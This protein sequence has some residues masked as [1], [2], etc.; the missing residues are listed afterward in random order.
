MNMLLCTFHQ[1]YGL[2]CEGRVAFKIKQ[3]NK[4]YD[5]FRTKSKD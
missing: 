3:I 4:G 5:L 1:Y 2:Y